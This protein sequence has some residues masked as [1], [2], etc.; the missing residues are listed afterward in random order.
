MSQVFKY[1]NKLE[2][3]NLLDRFK[4]NN[5]YANYTHMYMYQI[6]ATF[7]TKYNITYYYKKCYGNSFK[8][9]NNTISKS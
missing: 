6:Y 8:I 4:N 5:L 9:Y 2:Y 3:Q 7:Y 1:K